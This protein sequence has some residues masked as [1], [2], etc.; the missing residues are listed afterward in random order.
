MRDFSIKL[1]RIG[2]S[3]SSPRNLPVGNNNGNGQQGPWG[4]RW[5]L[6]PGAKVDYRQL[7][8]DAW[9]NSVVSISIEYIGR[10]LP[11]APPCVFRDVP[12]P[13]GGS[14]EQIDPTHPLTALMKRPNK[15]YDGDVLRLSLILS[16]IA[17]K[18]NA[19]VWVRYNNDGTPGE[20]WWL[21]SW[22]VWPVWSDEATTENWI[23]GY[24][25]RNNGEDFFLSNEEVIHI[26]N[27]MDPA[28]QRMGLDPLGGNYREVVTD[29]EA[30]GY[31]AAVLKNCGVI[32]AVISPKTADYEF[33]DSDA[34]ELKAEAEANTTG[35][36][37]GRYLVLKGPVD[38][39]KLGLS[40]KDLFLDTVQDR[41]EARITAVIGINSVAMG[42]TIGLEHSTY[43]NYE[44]AFKAA[45]RDGILP[46]NAKISRAYDTQLLPLYGKKSEAC[47]VG[48]DT[49]RVAVLNESMDNMYSRVTDAVGGP[50]MT[51]NEARID[52]G[53][54]PIDGGDELISA[55]DPADDMEGDPGAEAGDKK[56]STKSLHHTRGEIVQKWRRRKRETFLTHGVLSEEDEAPTFKQWV[57]MPNG[58]HVN[59]GQNGEVLQGL[60]GKAKIG[61][62]N[63]PEK[64]PEK[65]AK[66]QLAQQTSK[67]IGAEVQRYSEEH[68]EAG[69][70][71]A[72]GGKLE[73]KDAPTKIASLR[74]N[75]PVDISL[76]HNGV[77]QH[78]IELKTMTDNKNGQIFIKKEAQAR[79]DKWMAENHAPIH[80]VVFDDQK[81]YNAN[82]PGKHDESK[83]KMYYRRGYANFSVTAMHP[84]ENVADLHKLMNTPDKDLP[85]KAQ[86]PKQYPGVKPRV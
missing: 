29:N 28:N 78:G 39:Q 25:Y 35:D 30:A 81:V 22:Q 70:A 2:F 21:P 68:N 27:G 20:L 3:Y 32:P 74:D 49:R 5:G 24:N 23:S 85:K 45:W 26:R 66:S 64:V 73:A 48:C 43:S 76:S 13:A 79:K 6:L 47:R 18:G 10:N 67:K 7:A 40:P 36:N 41:G 55:S 65:S 61:S 17:C 51:P 4:F 9:R 86:P 71:K 80:V 84:V 57:T 33:D 53:L 75:E 52:A 69:L 82:G 60:G 44:E 46:W 58:E 54:P 72:L 77:I 34:K 16:L 38:V 56:P 12:T 8:G 62:S 19:Y 14:K 11:E 1:G 37:R 50:W 83:R 31:A 63:P 42:L 59:L 15:F